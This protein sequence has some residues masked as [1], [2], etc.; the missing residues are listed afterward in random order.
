[1]LMK[2]FFPYIKYIIGFFLTFLMLPRN[3]Y[4][5]DYINAS[6]C[7]GV[8]SVSQL[9]SYYELGSDIKLYYGRYWSDWY[10]SYVY[11]NEIPENTTF[12]YESNYTKTYTIYY[13]IERTR[14]PDRERT[15][16]ILPP[17]MSCPS[18]NL[19]LTFSGQ[20]SGK[21]V[22][23]QN[24]LRELNSSRSGFCSLQLSSNDYYS[25]QYT[26]GATYDVTYYL[27]GSS[28]GCPAKVIVSKPLSCPD[29]ILSNTFPDEV[30]QSDVLDF[31]VTNN[32]TRDGYMSLTLDAAEPATYTADNSP[33]S[34]KYYLN[35]SSNACTANITVNQPVAD[36]TYCKNSGVYNVTYPSGFSGGY[37]LSITPGSGDS[38]VWGKVPDEDGKFAFKNPLGESA[39]IHVGGKKTTSST[40]KEFQTSLTTINISSGTLSIPDQNSD[41]SFTFTDPFEVSVTTDAVTT[42]KGTR[43]WYVF[44]ATDF[45][46]SKQPSSSDFPASP[47]KNCK[48]VLV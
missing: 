32:S 24:K 44:S 13:K 2:I 4:A 38:P 14:V 25:V 37:Y 42:H 6:D 47:Q 19:T 15:F 35:G 43:K 3:V 34:V 30:D 5:L 11:Q 8:I 48:R 27:N 29:P 12:N 1:M 23:V 36:V 28:T 20:P 7:N 16:T 39:T 17:A 31:L 40:T 26:E 46:K 18:P 41:G 21:G 22:D 10:M 45:P 9:R 33:Y